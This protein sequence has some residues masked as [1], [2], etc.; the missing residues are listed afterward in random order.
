MDKLKSEFV[1]H[2]VVGLLLLILFIGQTYIFFEVNLCKWLAP[3]EEY[4]T[5][6]QHVRAALEKQWG[7]MLIWP[8]LVLAWW[9]GGLIRI[10]KS[11]H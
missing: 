7:N 10:K 9:I 5:V 2:F 8:F 11:K 4:D 3:F 6:Y 1:A